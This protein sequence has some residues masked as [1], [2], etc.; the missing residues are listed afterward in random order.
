[1]SLRSLTDRILDV[2][3]LA[4]RPLTAAEIRRWLPNDVTPEEVASCLVKMSRRGQVEFQMVERKAGTGPR[5]VKAY[6]RREA[7]K[8]VA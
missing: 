2:L 1:M 8:E 6:A 5:Q 3:E 4:L 7:T